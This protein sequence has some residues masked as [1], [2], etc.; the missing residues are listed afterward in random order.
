MSLPG[1]Y[2]ATSGLLGEGRS[3]LDRA[4]AQ[5]TAP[6]AARAE[7]LLVNS[8]LA[9]GQGDFAAAMRLLDEGEELARQL[10]ASAEVGHAAYLRGVG[11]LFAGDLPGAVE[12]LNRARTTLAGAPHRELDLSLYLHVLHVL[13][14]HRTGRRP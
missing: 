1:P 13:R 4:L 11:A 6:T 8:F 12:A 10:N 2:W 5:A 3:W 7:A 9:L 14:G